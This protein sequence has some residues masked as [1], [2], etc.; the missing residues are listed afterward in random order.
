VEPD[1]SYADARAR[2]AE[3]ARARLGASAAGRYAALIRPSVGFAV[4]RETGTVEGGCVIGG[5]PRLPGGVAWPRY[6]ERPMVL[7]A[8]LDCAGLARVTG[9]DWVLPP[10]GRL[11]F[12]HDQY[13]AAEFSF[14]HGDDGCRVLHVP[15]TGPEVPAPE[16]GEAPAYGDSFV[17]PALPLEPS[18]LVSAPG[19]REDVAGRDFLAFTG[20]EEALRDVLPAPRHRLLGWCD[21]DTS[22]PQGHRPLLQIEAEPGMHGWGEI[23]NVSFWIRE[24]DLYAGEFSNVRRS[25][26]VA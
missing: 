12:F 8:R 2:V 20:L 25:F 19:L 5:L 16:D 1:G 6:Y 22:R 10:A 18:K 11:L 14:G 26:D 24:P 13:F 17:I 9:G 15:G 7:L 3:V 21:T 23:V 4:R